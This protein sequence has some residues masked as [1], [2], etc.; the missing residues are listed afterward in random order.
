M[1]VKLPE[2]EDKRAVV[3]IKK[4]KVTPKVYPRKA[5]TPER[6]PIV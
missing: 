5:G 2:L 6:N 3:Y 1:P 4:E